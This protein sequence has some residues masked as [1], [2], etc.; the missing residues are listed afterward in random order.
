MSKVEDH[1]DEM[2][3]YS[4]KNLRPMIASE[5]S[6]KSNNIDPVA[7]QE[8]ANRVEQFINM[9]NVVSVLPFPKDTT[10]REDTAV[11]QQCTASASSITA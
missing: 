3:C 2:F 8:Q 6:S 1:N 11:V 5:N 7:I 4:W 9:K 10:E